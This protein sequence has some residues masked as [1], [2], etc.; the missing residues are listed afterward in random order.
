MYIP[1]MKI[2]AVFAALSSC[3]LLLITWDGL[4]VDGALIKICFGNRQLQKQIC[5]LWEK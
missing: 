1:W 4:Y 3:N 5:M 2:N